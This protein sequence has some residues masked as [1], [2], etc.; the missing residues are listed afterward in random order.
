MGWLDISEERPGRAAETICRHQTK[1]SS[2]P[3]SIRVDHARELGDG[4]AR[5]AVSNDR[6]TIDSRGTHLPWL[7][8]RE[9]VRK[10]VVGMGQIVGYQDL[11]RCR[12]GPAG[13][14]RCVAPVVMDCL[15]RVFPKRDRS[16]LGNL[17]L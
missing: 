14:L 3:R 2:L 5:M 15:V 8:S 6:F 1:R 10:K 13:P 12:K 9:G 7:I 16:R 11:V 17:W 4:K